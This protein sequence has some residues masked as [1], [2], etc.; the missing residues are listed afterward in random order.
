MENSKWGYCEEHE[1]VPYVNILGETVCHTC[2]P[3]GSNWWH[4]PLAKAEVARALNVDVQ[5][6]SENP[7]WWIDDFGSPTG[8]KDVK[9]ERAY[10]CPYCQE[11]IE[12]YIVNNTMKWRCNCEN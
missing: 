1:Y 6:F 7:V 11:W 5:F 12:F 10:I 2:D 9:L 3:L 4:S 8:F